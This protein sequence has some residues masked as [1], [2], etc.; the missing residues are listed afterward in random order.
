MTVSNIYKLLDKFEMMILKG[1]PIPVT[2]WVIVHHEKLID[3]LDKIRTSLPGD[4]QEAH[5]ILK[6]SDDIQMEAQRKANQILMEAKQ[7]AE[8][9]LSESELLRAVQSEA[10]RIRKQV[11]TD[12]EI[13]KKQVNEEV[14]NI[15]NSAVE[16]SI[17]VREGADRYAETVLGSLD[18]DLAELHSIVRNGQKHLAKIKTES[19]TTITSQRALNS[20]NNIQSQVANQNILNK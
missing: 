13:V 2:P 20:F 17:A 12:C 10:E 14:E 4:I 6:R 1:M 18:K 15:R 9:L 3:V 16:E 7:Q 19:I 11:I 8:S 5:N